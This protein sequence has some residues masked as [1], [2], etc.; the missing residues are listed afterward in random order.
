MPECDKPRGGI[1]VDEIMK[2]LDE[3]VERRKII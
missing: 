2:T 3:S 1:K